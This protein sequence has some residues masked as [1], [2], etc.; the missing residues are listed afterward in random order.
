MD[1]KGRLAAG[2]ALLVF[3]SVAQGETAE[4]AAKAFGAREFIQDIS[5]SPSGTKIAYISPLG[6]TGEAVYVV[7]LAGDA[8]PR[9]ILNNN[10]I[11]TDLTY[12]DW[13]T[14]RRIVCNIFGVDDSSGI[15]LQFTR[16]IAVGADGSDLDIL[17]R[18]INSRSVGFSQFGGRVLSLD[19]EGEG[20]KILMSRNW[21]PEVTLGTR[22]ANKEDGLGV[23]K[24]DINTQSSSRV[25]SPDPAA[26]RYI[27]DETG[28][29]R[30]KARLPANA[31]GTLSNKIL[32]F[33]RMADSD[34]WHRLGS[35]I[36]DSQTLTGFQPI[37]VDAAKNIVYGVDEADGYEAIFSVALDGTLKREKVFGRSDV[38]VDG[39]IRIGGGNRVVGVSFATEKRQVVYFDAELKALA[40]G[41][42]AALPG[43]PLVDI[44]DAD[45]GEDKLLIIAS[46]DVDPGMA[47][48]YDKQTR[49]L[50]ELLPLRAGMTGRAM[51]KMTPVDF[52]A[53]DGTLIPGYLTLPPGVQE[54]KGLPAIVLPHGGPSA[55][56]EWGF[57]WL[58]Q[59]FTAR[60]Y[61]VLQ[62]NFRGSSGYGSE[63][64]GRNGFKAWRTAV[65]DV[66]D[67]GRWLVNQGIAAPDRLAIVGWSY[68]GYAALQSQVLDPRLY[69]AVVAIAPVTDLDRL[70]E[71][72]RNYTNYAL[73]SSFIGKGPHVA[74]GS[75]ARNAE[76]FAAPVML[77]HGTLDQ[78]VDVH[79][80]RLMK[81]R[82]EEAGK[83]V[84]Y[85]E[86]EDLDHQLDSSVA[87][88][89]MLIDI[90]AFLTKALG[91]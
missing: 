52:P 25:E 37:T 12:C 18:T 7:D 54:A 69:K 50:D 76:A 28:R 90:D 33:Y 20:D 13:A 86:F 70:R 27:A 14:E 79:Q 55:R 73:V 17:S 78:N 39:L 81:D 10:Q 64:F 71:D 4:E 61:A 26:I 62:P 3:G 60:G 19:V 68:G 2:A 57:D 22:M 31:S 8:Q 16:I 21:T 1:W 41:L 6:D 43:K 83:Q 35:A 67:A 38:D 88:E 53:A 36:I 42:S 45:D 23:E 66:N 15:A 80:S 56:D 11:K 84:S 63:W 24:V 77:V 82:L 49:Q 5:L 30:I 87:R 51:G 46:S 89:R 91:S 32:Y 9:A 59:F 40:K 34:E 47:Y 74:R 65:G 72:A 29:V 75:P 44:V 48:L 85:L 58:V